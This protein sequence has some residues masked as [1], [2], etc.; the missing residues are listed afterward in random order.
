MLHP[1]ARRRLAA[2][3][4][5]TALGIG[6]LATT[7]STAHAAAETCQSVP[8]TIVG[9]PSTPFLTGTDGPDVIVSNGT[10]QVTALGGDDIICITAATSARE[11]IVVSAG[12]GND[13]VTNLRNGSATKARVDL[14]AGDDVY[15]G[16]GGQDVV[17]EISGEGDEGAGADQIRTGAG[18]DSVTT[19]QFAQPNADLVDLGD[20]RDELEIRSLDN[21]AATLL[22]GN[23][24]D[25]L[26]KAF[27]VTRPAGFWRFDNSTQTATL[28]G[29]PQIV[30]SSFD[31]FDLNNFANEQDVSFVGSSASETVFF[32]SWFTDVSMGGGN[33]TIIGRQIGGVDNSLH[34]SRLAGGS[35]RDEFQFISGDPFGLVATG[36]L[37]R[38]S[39]VVNDKGT[40]NDIR[41]DL[42]SV[43]DLAFEGREV[44]VKGDSK[45]NRLEATGCNVTAVG[46]GGNDRVKR[47]GSDAFVGQNCLKRLKPS[48]LLG[49][50]GNDRITGA[51]FVDT[52]I[53]G[54]G[55]D[56]ASGRKGR[57]SCRAEVERSCERN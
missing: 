12:A 57:D 14:G 49:G 10:P 15:T 51:N 7:Q 21:R 23:G 39:L 25:Q 47:S 38:G 43:E 45:A 36:D 46:R 27:T 33:D 30:W 16:S 42:S 5:A 19:G 32:S 11:Q 50:P 3:A 24:S 56:R 35:G 41:A 6:V 29:V 20:G 54:P 18:S 9:S 52:L 8:A 26:S 13:Q 37:R 17:R 2:M 55:R 53:G 44:T 48:R 40:F 31:R 28:D 4:V 22:G 1:S 34:R